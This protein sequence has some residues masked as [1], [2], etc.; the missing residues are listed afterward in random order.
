MQ[1]TA[2]LVKAV[3]PDAVLALGDNQYPSGSLHDFKASYARN[4]GVFRDITYPVP[5]NHEYGTPRAEGYFSYFG[6]RAGEPDKGYYSYDLGPWHMVALNSECENVGGCSDT[7]PQA[8]W[9]KQDLST[10]SRTCTLAYWHRPRF[11][12]GSHGN[13]LDNDALWRIVV[14][15]NVDVVLNGHDHG[16]ERFAPMDS[17]GDGSATGTTEMVVGTG[18]ASHYEFHLPSETSLLRVRGQNGILRLELTEQGYSWQFLRSPDQKILDSGTVPATEQHTGEQEV[19]RGTWP[20]E[21]KLICLEGAQSP[22]IN[23]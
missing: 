10:H 9:L 21:R 22:R 7:S 4:W 17:D 1:D 6:S 16:Y 23:R 18:G 13:N 19:R 3:N 12:S 2:D 11:S 15:E 8:S 20:E 14:R 5:G